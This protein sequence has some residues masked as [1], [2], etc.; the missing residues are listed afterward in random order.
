MI[1]KTVEWP[2]AVRFARTR[3]VVSFSAL[4]TLVPRGKNK[5]VLL[6]RVYHAEHGPYKNRV[7]ALH[8][9]EGLG[10]KLTQK[11]FTRGSALVEGMIIAEQMLL[12]TF[13]REKWKAVHEDENDTPTENQEG[14]SP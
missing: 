10:R 4:C 2:C 8:Y 7:A 9:A 5:V 1:V 3:C 6:E 11:C 14:V 13:D 12:G